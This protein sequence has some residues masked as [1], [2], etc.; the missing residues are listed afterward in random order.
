VFVLTLLASAAVL[1]LLSFLARSLQNET[2][3]MYGWD[4]WL[5]AGVTMALTLLALISAKLIRNLVNVVVLLTLLLLAAFLRPFDGAMGT[6]SEAAQREVQGKDV[7]VSC[8]FRAHDEGHRFLL[9]NARVHGY[10]EY[11]NLTPEELAARYKIFALQLPMNAEACAGCRVIGQRL[12]IRG[13]HSSE[14]LKAMLK[15]DVY[16]HLFVKELLIESPHTDFDVPGA[17]KEGCH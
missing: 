17:N 7:W 4:Y 3:G 16:Q 11:W 12:D 6:Y 5:L 9:P 14:E 2:G 1:L 8:N 15:G 10:D 13:R